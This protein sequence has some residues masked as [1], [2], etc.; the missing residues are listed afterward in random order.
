[1]D[2]WIVKMLNSERARKLGIYLLLV[3][4][5]LSAIAAVYRQLGGVSGGAA[6]FYEFYMVSQS[7]LYGGDH[8]NVITQTYPP[9]FQ[10]LLWPFSW[11]PLW[12]A[13]FLWFM[14]CSWMAYLSVKIMY[15][16]VNPEQKPLPRIYFGVPVLMVVTLFL[17]DLVMGNVNLIILFTIVSGLYWFLQQRPYRSGVF[18][19]MGA[20]TKI[21]PFLFI[22]YFLYKRQYR[23]VVAA[24]LGIILFSLL[25]PPVFLGD[26][27]VDI[28]TDWGERI[29]NIVG[30]SNDDVSG[31]WYERDDMLT[32]SNQSL[33]AF[34][35]RYMRDIPGVYGDEDTR[36]NVVSL[37][38]DAVNMIFYF[39]VMLL[40]MYLAYLLRH[41]LEPVSHANR[42]ILEYSIMV[43][44]LLVVSP[45]AWTNYYLFLVI[46]YFALF[47][48]LR[49]I[50]KKSYLYR[51]LPR[52]FLFVFVL[53]IVTAIPYI[54]AFG[55]PFLALLTVMG[56]LMWAL[57]Y[58]TIKTI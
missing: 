41:K 2:S 50:E 31:R 56:M 5:I 4:W 3:F 25:L 40:A 24:F 52:Y 20:S 48:Q 10:L 43:V 39:L 7:F 44:T 19:A 46:A 32:A 38:V 35:S 45:L 14:F 30:Q 47:H 55:I 11:L 57:R 51:V 42:Y 1:M 13:S 26:K 37:G 58:T 36:I 6:D 29:S 17:N 16:I 54:S 53:G 18:L 28:V 21:L 27:G 34:L 33:Y 22:L 12:L 15:R 8:S 49:L 23:V 9:F